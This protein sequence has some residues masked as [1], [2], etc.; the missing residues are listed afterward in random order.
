LAPGTALAELYYVYEMGVGVRLRPLE[1]GSPWWLGKRAVDVV[2][3]GLALVVVGPLMVFLAL[4]VRLSSPGPVVLRQAR[5]GLDGV[6]FDLFKFRSMRVFP[7]SDTLWSV[8]S[9]DPRITP[10]GR[11]LRRSGLDE[12]PQLINV[13]RGDMSLVGPRPER[14][15]FAD[16]FAANVPGYAERNR[17]RGGLTG[18]AQIH[19]LRGDTS[20]T[21]RTR[22]DLEYME[23]WSIWRD[24]II[25]IGTVPAL[26]RGAGVDD[27][28]PRATSADVDSAPE[29]LSTQ[30]E[31]G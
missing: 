2:G 13:V 10:L 30:R 16:N 25:I 5:V 11:L 17:V 29:W 28:P 3:A 20:I 26:I 9:T 19:G 23:E 7:D 18:W 22:L 27:A 12:L 1:P 21:E 6:P 14:P 15:H 8:G 24:V 4:A 31:A